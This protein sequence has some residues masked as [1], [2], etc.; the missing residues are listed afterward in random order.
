MVRILQKKNLL[1]PNP[2]VWLG[3]GESCGPETLAPRDRNTSVKFTTG[4]DEC[5][6]TGPLILDFEVTR[7]K[8]CKLLFHNGSIKKK[9][10]THGTPEPL[11]LLA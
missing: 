9:V 1:T 7:E 5:T 10:L 8:K 3:V 4:P 11:I 2:T 6:V